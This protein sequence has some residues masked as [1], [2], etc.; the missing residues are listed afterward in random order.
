M[1]N[2][3]KILI[4][5]FF[6]ASI[7]A[8]FGC[9]K[10]ENIQRASEA[11]K[12]IIS[13]YFSDTSLE[14]PPFLL[15]SFTLE[16]KIYV[17]IYKGKNINSSDLKLEIEQLLVNYCDILE[18][19]YYTYEELYKKLVDLIA[20]LK[21]LGFSEYI[22]NPDINK[23]TGRCILG[24]SNGS[25]LDLKPHIDAFLSSSGI[26]ISLEQWEVYLD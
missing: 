20:E 11:N 26:Y 17:N 23:L 10:N 7:I 4:I 15:G 25:A 19:N 2:F 12:I 14:V 24:V 3:K 6:L 16:G 1:K 22:I 13:S 21:M 18:F 8:M 9:K 5:V